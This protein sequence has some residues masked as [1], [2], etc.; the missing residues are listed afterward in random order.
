MRSLSFALAFIALV[1][2]LAGG[3]WLLRGN[4]DAAEIARGAE[5]YD[6]YCA[7][8]HGANLEGQPDWQTRLPNGRMPAPP[9]DETG[10]TWHHPDRDLFRI[11]KEGVEAI[12][13]GYQSD[14][15]GFGALLSDHD[16][17]AVIA[18]IKSSWPARER[19]YQEARNGGA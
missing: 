11:V 1:A 16:I 8:C 13:P 2:L 19:E 5:V 10:H 9:H 14:M 3:W 4:P 17:D 15:M 12:V 18:F 6:S 7:S